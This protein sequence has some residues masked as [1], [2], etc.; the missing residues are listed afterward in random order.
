ML[1]RVIVDLGTEV[2]QVPFHH[3]YR[4]PPCTDRRFSDS[5]Y[6]NA[7][8]VFSGRLFVDPAGPVTMQSR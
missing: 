7:I 1:Q 6:L 3:S 5:L 8:C 4:E 2:D